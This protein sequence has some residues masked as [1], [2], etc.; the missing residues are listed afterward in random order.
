MA[1]AIKYVQ[2]V[3]ENQVVEVLKYFLV[4]ETKQAKFL[5]A[6]FNFVS[7]YGLKPDISNDQYLFVILSPSPFLC[8]FLFRSLI[9]DRKGTW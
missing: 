2:D 6:R 5:K 4:P 8:L 7:T 3:P 1:D 9:N